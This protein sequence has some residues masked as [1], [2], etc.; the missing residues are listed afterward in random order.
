MLSI[1]KNV[2]E[3][4]IFKSLPILGRMN[5]INR[6]QLWSPMIHGCRIIYPVRNHF[7]PWWQSRRRNQLL[8]ESYQFDHMPSR[9]IYCV[10]SVRSTTNNKQREKVERKKGNHSERITGTQKKEEK[11]KQLIF[12][13][14]G[15]NWQ[16]IWYMTIYHHRIYT[17]WGRL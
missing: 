3:W 7:Q 9:S 15:A 8:L 16:R 13:F 11:K 2:N 17:W 12:Y 1:R 6:W 14:L 4:T 10:I 5:Q